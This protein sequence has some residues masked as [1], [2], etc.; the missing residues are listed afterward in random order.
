[1]QAASAKALTYPNVL[2]SMP[3]FWAM[4]MPNQTEKLSN[5]SASAQRFT[6][7]ARCAL[8]VGM[9]MVGLV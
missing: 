8:V 3:F 4:S 9:L 1:M 5:N 2:C 6:V 7:D